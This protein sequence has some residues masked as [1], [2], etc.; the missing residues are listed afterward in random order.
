MCNV[1]SAMVMGTL[2]RIAMPMAARARK[3][4]AKECS[5]ILA[6]ALGISQVIARG[7]RS[8]RVMGMA[9]DIEVS[10]G[11]CLWL[12]HAS[13]CFEFARCRRSCARVWCQV[14]GSRRYALAF[15]LV[16]TC[17]LVPCCCQAM[18]QWC[19]RMVPSCW[20]PSV[21]FFAHVWCE[22]LEQLCKQARVREAWA[23]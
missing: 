5:A 18:A 14:V 17:T 13:V 3:A 11:L 1:I 21:H 10:I 7:V 8:A 20:Q 15:V 19:A 16:L 22:I 12:S 9:V 6:R 23:L 2:P 4:K